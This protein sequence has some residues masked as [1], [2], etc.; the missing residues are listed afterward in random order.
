V[1]ARLGVSQ[2]LLS[3]VERGQGSLD[4]VLKVCLALGV[5]A[6]LRIQGEVFPLVHA[7]DHRERQEIDSNLEW[8]SR[9]SPG[10]RLRA[11]R[12]HF[13]SLMKLREAAAAAS[14]EARGGA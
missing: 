1:A 5:P 3:K 7:I 13:L 10:D 9:L 14:K 12:R 11:A 8:F 4:Q 6:E 2:Q